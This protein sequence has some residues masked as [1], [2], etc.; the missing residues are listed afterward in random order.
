M[1]STFCFPEAQF[2]LPEA[3]LCF[4]EASRRQHSAYGKQRFILQETTA[5]LREAAFGLE[6]ATL[7]DVRGKPVD[8]RRRRGETGKHREKLT[9]R[10][11]QNSSEEIGQHLRKRGGTRGDPPSTSDI[12]GSGNP[13]F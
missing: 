2:C 11:D 8:V 1:I 7:E 12:E 6:E 3:N 13:G 9:F 10:G 5:Y 4:P